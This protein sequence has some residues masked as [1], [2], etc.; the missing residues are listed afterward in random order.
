[1]IYN[2]NFVYFLVYLWADGSVERRRFMLEIIE[3]DAIEILDDIKNID[4]LNIKTYKRERKDRKPQICIY[5]CNVKFYDDF[6]SKYFINKSFTSPDKLLKD[7]PEE[8]RRYFYLGLVDGDGC[9]YFNNKLRQFY[10]TS[11]YNQ[12]W[13]YLECLFKKL[14]I[15]QYE[16]K[17]VITKSGD[18]SSYIRIKKYKEI[19]NL[20]NYLYPDNYE[21]GLNRK[22]N[23]CKEIIDNPPKYSSNKSNIDLDQLVSKINDGLNIIEI[24]NYFDCS[25]RKIYNYCKKNDIHYS[26]GFFN[27]VNKN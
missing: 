16:I 9:F 5:F 1:M 22:Y 23:K 3:E 27:G 6:L 17:R 20:Y 25:W 7:I 11:S 15:T 12:D 4:F 19:L 8:L 24:S 26:K 2:K 10:V 18:K 14:D 13:N 21:I